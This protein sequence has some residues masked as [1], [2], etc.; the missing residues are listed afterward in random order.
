MDI[1]FT[2]DRSPALIEYQTDEFNPEDPDA[3]YHLDRYFAD[4]EYSDWLR[5]NF[6]QNEETHPEEALDHL[7]TLE[8]FTRMQTEDPNFTGGFIWESQHW[9]NWFNNTQVFR[10][11]FW[12][13]FIGEPR[14]GPSAFPFLCKYDYEGTSVASTV[15][16]LVF[17]TLENK[18]PEITHFGMFHIRRGDAIEEC[19]TTL[20]K[21]SNY[22]SCSLDRIEMY[23]N[24]SIMLS[25][26]E[27]DPC[28]RNAIQDMIEALGFHFVDLDAIVTNVV[29]GYAGNNSRLFSTRGQ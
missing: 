24:I 14:H 1:R 5:L 25:S 12:E 22:L 29:T 7:A 8:T 6:S 19:D 9:F 10:K 11:H 20:G 4:G 3:A 18:Y 15:T 28:Y 16:D 13:R 27:Q 21:I 2:R 23:G 26:D 17:D